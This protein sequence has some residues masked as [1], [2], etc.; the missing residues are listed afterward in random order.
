[1]ASTK[2]FTIGLI[3]PDCATGFKVTGDYKNPLEGHG[4]LVDDILMRITG[5][6]FTISS[7]RMVLLTKNQVRQLYR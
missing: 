7:K 1:M 6:G 2:A 5:D 3:K 4:K